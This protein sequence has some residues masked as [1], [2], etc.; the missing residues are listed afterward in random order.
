MGK[1]DSKED[2]PPLPVKKV[3]TLCFIQLCD[4]INGSAI[5]PY[6]VFMVQSFNLTEDEKNLGYVEYIT[7]LSFK[8][9]FVADTMQGSLDQRITLHNFFQG[10]Y[11]YYIYLNHIELFTI[12][13]F[14]IKHA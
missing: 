3:L 7:Y 2:S 8:L 13:S 6:I 5:Y 4:Q 1:G 12:N 9:T 10:I 14:C 11:Y